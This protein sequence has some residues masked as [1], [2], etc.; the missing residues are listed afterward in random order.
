MPDGVFIHGSMEVVGCRVVVG[1]MGVARIMYVWG[2]QDSVEIM[3]GFVRLSCCLPRSATGPSRMRACAGAAALVPFFV[4]PLPCRAMSCLHAGRR[5][6]RSCCPYCNRDL[7]LCLPALIR[8]SRAAFISLFVSSSPSYNF[9]IPL[10]LSALSSCDKCRIV[11][12][13]RG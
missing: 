2:I 9:F 3:V 12:K 5:G 1:F 6:A 8:S 10:S 7:S 13:K 11:N 4:A